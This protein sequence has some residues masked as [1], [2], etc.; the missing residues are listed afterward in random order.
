MTLMR[1][2]LIISENAGRGDEI[3]LALES[4]HDVWNV[5][6]Q[7]DAMAYLQQHCPDTVVLDLNMPELDA[8]ALVSLI[9]G[10]QQGRS[11]LIIGVS[12][13]PH[14]I[15]DSL[16]CKFDQLAVQE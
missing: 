3:A 4:E 10:Q 11:V 15:T 16:A 13:D 12:K 2:A 1:T 7:R 8:E 5:A 14:S 6:R 9:R